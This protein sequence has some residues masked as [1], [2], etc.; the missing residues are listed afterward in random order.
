MA[1]E[2]KLEVLQDKLVDRLIDKVEDPNCRAADLSVMAQFLR[3][4]DVT[5]EQLRSFRGQ[6]EH[7]AAMVNDLPNYEEGGNRFDFLSEEAE[8]V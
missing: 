1:F 6:A 8:T 3:T 4:H 5:L 7:T 2:D